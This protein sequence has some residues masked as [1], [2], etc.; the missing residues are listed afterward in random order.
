MNPNTDRRTVLTL[1]AGGTNFVFTAI[2]SN[3][4][5]VKPITLPSR[6]DK[7]EKCIDTIEKGFREIM[8]GLDERAVAISFA[9][10]GPSDYDTGII[11]K[12]NNLPAFT[13][14]IPLGPIL[15]HRFGI[16][17]FINNDGDLYA[18]GE[19]LSGFL[20]DL[21][22]RLHEAGIKKRFRNLMG[23]TLGTGFGGGLVFNE[24][25]LSG[26]NSMAGEIWLLRNKLNPGTNAEEGVSIRAIQRVFA[27]LAGIPK[28]QCPSPKEI[29]EI[30]RKERK[31]NTEA[32]LEA[33]R[34]LGIVLGDTLGNLFTVFDGA[35]V[36][37]GGLSGAMSLIFPSMMKELNDRYTSYS[38]NEY[39]RLV[40]KVFNIS[41]PEG[42]K[43]FLAWKKQDIPVPDTGESV[44]YYAQARLPIGLS[45][46]GTS[47][48]VALGAYAFALKKL[49]NT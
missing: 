42:M 44:S 17:V 35:C 30:A 11:G 14:G 10:P 18:Y 12:L 22:R 45:S 48:A 39:P 47:R 38:G 16:P 43:Q 40:Q 15:E 23:I 29:Y 7:L 27:K 3:K 37:G 20:P 4:E 41:T 21:N 31:G 49:D 32:A 1:D 5:I 6:G 26:D 8:A 33:F 36:I 28:N 13:G 46:I 24:E 9:F 34:Q 2:R 25:L 19:A